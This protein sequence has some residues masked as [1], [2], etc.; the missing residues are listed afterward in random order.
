MPRKKIQQNPANKT[1]KRPIKPFNEQVLFVVGVIIALVLTASAVL[2]ET[3]S[4]KEWGFSATFPGQSKMSAQP[5]QT[6]VGKVTLVTYISENET[7]A[8]MVAVNDYP[9][10]TNIS[11]NG[12]IEGFASGVKGTL[13]NRV[14]YKL[15]NVSGFDFL[16]DGPSTASTQKTTVFHVRDFIVGS[17]MYQ[18]GYTG[19]M[20]TEQ[21]VAALRFLNSFKFR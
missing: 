1:G 17:R 5:I 10:D 7:Q 8:F 11:Y 21:S 19:P 2:A 9:N 20:G 13:R 12:A 6:E 15:G 3:V 16:V 4:S 18:I 14:P